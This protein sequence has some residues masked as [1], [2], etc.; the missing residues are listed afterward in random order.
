MKEFRY[1]G[2]PMSNDKVYGKVTGH[3]VYTSDMQSVDMLHLKYKMSEIGHGMITKID[4]SRAWLPGVRAIYTWE[5]TPDTYFDR[6]RVSNA[7][8]AGSMNQERLFDREVRFYG[9]RVAAVVAETA[10]IAQEACQ[11]I[12][13]EYQPLPLI[14]TLEESMAEDAPL[15]HHNGNIYPAPNKPFHESCGNYES[16][17]SDLTVRSETHMGRMTHLSMET[18]SVRAK[19]DLGTERLTV[20]SGCQTSYGIRS[21]VADY[22]GLPYSRVRVIKPPMGGSFGVKQE[23]VLEPLVAYAAYDL[24]A[25]VICHFTRE[26]QTTGTLL[27]HNFDAYTETKVTKDGIIKGIKIRMNLEAGA[28]QTISPSYLRTAGGKLGKTYQCSN[29]DFSGY[30]YCTTTPCNGSFRSWGASEEAVMLEPNVNLIAEKLGID[31]VELRLRNIHEA[32]E[33]DPMHKANIGNAH[34][35]EVLEQG[36]DRFQWEKRKQDC[37][38]KN[39]ENGRYRYGVGVAL[40]SHKTSFYPDLSEIATCTIMLQDDGSFLVNLPVHDHGCGATIAMRKFAAEVLDVDIRLIEVNEADTQYMPYDYGC[41]GSRTIYVFGRAV[42]QC[43]QEILRQGKEI[44]ASKLGVFSTSI[45]Y[46]DSVFWS[47]QNPEKKCTWKEVW[48]HAIFDLQK[49]IYYT[50]SSNAAENP[51]TPAAFFAEVAVDTLLGRVD[52]LHCLSVHDIGK[53]IN[54]DLVHGEIGSGI[55]QGIGWALR[56]EIKIDPK[57]GKTLIPNLQHYEVVNAYDMPDYDLLLIE[58]PE[59]T[60]PFGAKGVGEVATAPIAPALGAAVNHALGTHI[61]HYPIT[62]PIILEAIAKKKGGQA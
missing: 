35:R 22:L 62:P 10:E 15:L 21:T 7:E 25:D 51:G 52:I 42:I 30:S 24:K 6:G 44:A 60:G 3:T 23:M 19:Y 20:W 57:T 38:K 48:E 16:V 37:E 11:K 49:D 61:T 4:T 36:R 5:N 46:A 53:A 54:P 18:Q 43:A 39:A 17:Q 27:R 28:Y 13:V 34:F 32:Y 58:D 26:E 50:C 14:M 12:Q 40:C 56:E 8:L 33:M 31:P 41:Y 45:H 2:K 9:E 1:I 59:P 55:Q 47:E 29:I